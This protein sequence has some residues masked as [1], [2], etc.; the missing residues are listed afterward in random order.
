MSEAELLA[1][2][3]GISA[4][5]IQAEEEQHLQEQHAGADA[6][7]AAPAAPPAPSTAGG[8]P[9]EQFLQ[10]NPENPELNQYWYSKP[11]IRRMADEVRA[12]GAPADAPGELQVA[13]VSTPSVFFALAAEER[14]GSAVLDFDRKWEAEPG[15]VFYDFNAP[16]AVP[17]ALHHRF[18][19][20]VVDPP[21]IVRDAWEKYATTVRVLLAPGGKILL[22]TIAENAAMMAE[23]LDVRPTQFRPSIPNLVY[24]YALYTNY[25]SPGLAEP[26]PEIDP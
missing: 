3:K 9:L 23:L 8:E 11:T 5:K 19:M 25:D 10:G 14:G 13:F 2:L 16:E 4:D 24:Q 12:H 1:M 6:A 26:N 7:A 18:A 22:S 15:F 21:F 17:E 20:V